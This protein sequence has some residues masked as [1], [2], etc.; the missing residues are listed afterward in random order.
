M[1]SDITAGTKKQS[2]SVQKHNTNGG[3]TPQGIN[4]IRSDSTYTDSLDLV[5]T[6]STEIM[7]NSGRL[8][9]LF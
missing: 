7:N 2:S 8:S 1:T 9:H 6:K 3:V 5:K 4:Y